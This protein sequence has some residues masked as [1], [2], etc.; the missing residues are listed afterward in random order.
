MFDHAGPSRSTL[1]S[2]L[3]TGLVLAVVAVYVWAVGADEIGAALGRATLQQGI[4]LAAVGMCP[5]VLWGG[6]LYVLLTAAGADIPPWKAVALFAASVFLNSITPFGQVGGNPPSALLVAR[7]GSARV[8]SGL[9]AF[10]AVGAINRTAALLIGGVGGLWFGTRLV[11]GGQVRRAVAVV[12]VL[13]TGALLVA[14][15]AWRHRR[16]IGS[17]VAREIGRAADL[18]DRRQS[19]VSVPDRASIAE[20]V[21]GFVRTCERIVSRPRA[22]TTVFLLGLAGQVVVAGVLAIAVAAVAADVPFLLLLVLVPAGKLAGIT[23]TPGGAGSAELLLSGLLVAGAGLASPTATAAVLLYRAAAF[24]LPTA[25][26]GLV[27][28]WIL[29]RSTGREPP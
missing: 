4:A 8:E 29:G 10:G 2:G 22:V 18:V 1:L 6:S 24:W 9:A 19:A 27:T 16:R 21:E 15:A 13:G 7:D 23:P 28:A 11:A 26:G 14:A 17:V 20:R 3:W 25:I 12:A 5:I